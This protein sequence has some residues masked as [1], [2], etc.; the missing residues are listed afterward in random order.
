M[1]LPNH[2]NMRVTICPAYLLKEKQSSNEATEPISGKL[3][4]QRM[5]TPIPERKL[6]ELVLDKLQKKD[7]Y[8]VFAEPVDPEEVPDYY[9]YIKN[10]MDF[11]TI[12]LKLAEGEYANLEQFE[13]DVFLICSNAM[14]YNA[15]STIYYRHA[16]AIQE[17]AQKYFQ[18]LRL[19]PEKILLEHKS[20]SNSKSNY[21]GQ[22]ISNRTPGKLRLE[23]GGSDPASGEILA[24]NG[25]YAN[26]LDTYLQDSVKLKK[27]DASERS[28][29]GFEYSNGT[30]Y[31]WR[32]NVDGN[33]L[34]VDS[35]ADHS[36]VFS[37]ASALKTRA[38]KDGRRALLWEDERRDTYRP[39]NDTANGDES[40]FAIPGGMSKRLIPIGAQSESAYARSLARFS[41]DLGPV[42][43]KIAAQ[44]IKKVWSSGAGSHL[45]NNRDIT[46]TSV[47][48]FS[49]EKNKVQP[50]PVHLA[51]HT[52]EGA[53]R[54]NGTLSTQLGRN[55]RF[56]IKG[57]CEG[58]SNQLTS[59]MSSTN[60][61]SPTNSDAH[62]TS[63]NCSFLPNNQSVKLNS[64]RE[65]TMDLPFEATKQMDKRSIAADTKF[66]S[67][68]SQ[69]RLLEI[70]SRNNKLMQWMP[71]QQ[72][73]GG[74]SIMNFRATDSQSVATDRGGPREVFD[75]S[76]LPTSSASSN[77]TL[78]RNTSINDYQDRSI[79][80]S[81]T[82]PAGE[83]FTA[84]G[85]NYL[86]KSDNSKM[87]LP[88]QKASPDIYAGTSL[89]SV[90]SIEPIV[91]QEHNT[92][93]PC[94]RSQNSD[95]AHLDAGSQST[96]NTIQTVSSAS[97]NSM[98][99]ETQPRPS[100]GISQLMQQQMLLDMS[101]YLQSQAIRMNPQNSS[102]ATLNISE[103]K[104][105]QIFESHVPNR[106]ANLKS[107]GVNE[108]SQSHLNSLKV[109]CSQENAGQLFESHVPIR[110]TNAKSLGGNES[111]QSHLNPLKV[112][113][114]QEH[115][116]KLSD[117]S[118]SVPSNICIGFQHP[119]SPVRESSET[120]VHSQ[121]PDL[122]LQL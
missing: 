36:E 81:S 118:H 21:S 61:K 24:T 86:S 43:W 27:G 25:N 19:D 87:F 42:A 63:A 101:S 18:M 107:L 114:S 60:T 69:S 20:P 33:S 10:P 62:R 54:F 75:T 79:A 90:S 113:C 109:V 94:I 73:D 76:K 83:N 45:E 74:Q 66:T 57:T 11:G 48:L 102:M 39:W 105:G 121:Q 7:K 49:I 1:Q 47:D 13:E 98:Q 46:A 4:E 64:V 22:K 28:G 88:L 106:M 84:R 6:L 67:E 110:M 50:K 72:A 9:E 71:T 55:E 120:L 122:A 116:Q 53:S 37:A 119:K 12:R 31:Q 80:A 95:I 41:A 100:S 56:L 82:R 111:P 117:L 59:T 26:L 85:L 44:K 29:T 96:H 93:Q 58:Q 15:S 23:S 5:A 16:R 2:M 78:T 38:V 92:L 115:F 77:V 97:L 8:E 89:L 99:S 91:T 52:D 35:K 112:A 65:P 17:L 51:L 14:S 104:A 34:A 40:A 30:G 103:E 32:N 3:T 68:V 108:L 70:V